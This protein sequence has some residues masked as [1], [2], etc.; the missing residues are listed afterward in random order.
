MRRSAFECVIDAVTVILR[1]FLEVGVPGN[2]FAENELAVDGGG[3]FSVGAAEVETDSASVE[4]PAERHGGL[5]R[6]RSI[7]IGAGYDLHPVAV[8]TSHHGV[9]EGAF[10]LGRVNFR[11]LFGDFRIPGDRDFPAAPHPEKPFHKTLDVSDVRRHFGGIGVVEYDGRINTD[12]FG[13]AFY[14]NDD[15]LAFAG[16]VDRFAELSVPEGRGNEIFVEAR[17]HC[18]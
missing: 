16:G 7:C 2:F 5:F 17:D 10:A 9:I 1:I 18:A 15:I 4:V 6:L 14:G 11:K 13:I 3:A 8:N 12:T